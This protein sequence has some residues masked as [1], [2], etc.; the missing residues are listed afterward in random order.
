[1]R[2][3]SRTL[4]PVTVFV[5]I[6]TLLLM[7]ACGAGK[8]QSGTGA[9]TPD[10]TES[11]AENGTA[12]QTESVAQ[13]E[14]ADDNS[15]HVVILATSDMHANVWGYAYEDNAETKNNGMARLYTYIQKMREENPDLILVD[16]GDD[17]QGTIM[18]DDIYNKSPDEPH[19]VMAAMNAMKYD[20]MTVGNHEFNWG[21][22]SM[23]K[24][25][26]QAEFPILA[27]NVTDKDGNYLT[28]SGWIIIDRGGVKVAVIGVCTPDVPIWDGGKEGISEYVFEPASAG[29]ARAIREIG[30]QADLIMVCAHMGMAAEFDEEGGSD[31]AK[32]ILEDNPE[33]DILQVAHMHITVNEKEG[34]VL[35]GAVRNAGVEICRFDIIFDADGN[36]TNSSVEIVPMEDVEPS[37][38]IRELPVVREAHEKTLR[39]IQG[40]TD[41]GSDEKHPLGTTTAKFQPEDEIRGLPEGKLRDTAVIDFINKVQLDAAGADVSS[42]SLFKTT[43]DLPEGDIFYSNV[44][45]IYEA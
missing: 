23:M 22:P 9:E 14:T 1:M 32:K 41:E 37:E 18:S 13:T 42:C 25:L 11:V 21:I 7:T 26:G 3:K 10:Q 24:I 28:G 5:V 4:F 43:S 36:I 2:R 38:V 31:S 29:V 12:A 45:D 8:T 30:G 20:A 33:V 44:F 39:F 40:M 35:I 19:P 17:I 15:R 34:D 16:A 27:A 6:F